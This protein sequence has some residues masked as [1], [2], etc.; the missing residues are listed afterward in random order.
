LTQAEALLADL[1]DDQKRAVSSSGAP[2]FAV[3]ELLLLVGWREGVAGKRGK[4]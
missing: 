4:T 2:L 1:D 3:R